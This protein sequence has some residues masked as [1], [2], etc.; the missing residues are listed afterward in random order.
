M[1]ANEMNRQAINSITE[2]LLDIDERIEQIKARY[3]YGV[4]TCQEHR[5]EYSLACL[6]ARRD[7]IAEHLENL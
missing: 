7:V 4:S 2:E 6:T 1:D 3:D 5:L